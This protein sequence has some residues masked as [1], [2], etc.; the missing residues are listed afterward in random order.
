MPQV[1]GV[2]GDLFCCCRVVF[3]QMS[4]DLPILRCV[5][6]M[7]GSRKELQRLRKWDNNKEK[8]LFLLCLIVFILIDTQTYFMM[9]CCLSQWPL[10]R[11]DQEPLDRPKP[12]SRHQARAVR[13]TEQGSISHECF[14]KKYWLF[15]FVFF[16]RD[17]PLTVLPQTTVAFQRSAYR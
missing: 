5:C 6:F 9:T 2:E 13:L 1:A 4:D 10:D 7:R 11:N 3:C 17:P 15:C 16:S 14:G 8:Q 12:P